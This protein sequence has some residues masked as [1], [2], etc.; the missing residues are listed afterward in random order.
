MVRA[1]DQVVTVSG[2][3]FRAL[4]LRFVNF[5]TGCRSSA[6]LLSYSRSGLKDRGAKPSSA[7]W[8]SIPCL[9]TRNPP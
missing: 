8:T 5:F 1:G 4:G 3:R 2:L 7:C 6:F 9:G